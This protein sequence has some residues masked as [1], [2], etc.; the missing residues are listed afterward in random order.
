MAFF[1]NHLG[2]NELSQ[3]KK[4][5]LNLAAQQTSDILLH[6]SLGVP[7]LGHCKPERL[8]NSLEKEAQVAEL[9]DALA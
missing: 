3:P 4:K 8:F 5:T 2:A 7:E 6:A 9:A 1:F